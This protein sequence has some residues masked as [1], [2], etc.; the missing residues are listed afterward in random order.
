[1]LEFSAYIEIQKVVALVLKLSVSF[2]NT[3]LHSYLLVH[4][5]VKGKR[6]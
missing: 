1:M 2:S 5:S 6:S 3:F 4:I